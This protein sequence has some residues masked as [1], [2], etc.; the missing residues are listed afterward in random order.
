MTRLRPLALVLVLGCGGETIQVGPPPT[1]PPATTALVAPPPSEIAEA[2][3]A[4]PAT[5]ADSDFVEAD[6]N[7][8]PFRAYT[9]LFVP[10]TATPERNQRI[11]IMRD[12]AVDEMHLIAIVS[13]VANPSAMLVGGDGTGHT[14]HRG[15][16]VGR[17]EVVQT[18]GEDSV[19]VTLNWRVERIRDGAVIL[20][21]EDPTAP[22][23]PPLT[24]EIALHDPSELTEVGG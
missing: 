6:T 11:V 9:N 17:A 15:D 7:R 21:R 18:G 3:T 16:F 23:R 12:T 5:Y 14:V 1:P 13:G 8:D 24:R 4:G 19:P 22:N 10:H 20:S 2:E